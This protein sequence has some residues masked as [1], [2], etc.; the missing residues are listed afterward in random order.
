[1]A[2]RTPNQ[3]QYL[4]AV[5]LLEHVV[6]EEYPKDMSLVQIVKTFAYPSPSTT[7]LYALGVVVDFLIES[8]I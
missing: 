5:D 7:E 8:R 2:A 4:I 6:R 1:M 3:A